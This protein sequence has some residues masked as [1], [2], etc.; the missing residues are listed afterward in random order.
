ML[1]RGPAQSVTLAGWPT[2]RRPASC[3]GTATAISV[4]PALGKRNDGLAG[5]N[6]L[7]RLGRDRRDDAGLVGLQ[8]RV[9]DRIGGLAQ[10]RFGASRARPRPHPTRC[11]RMS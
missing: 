10:L 11:V 8:R 7:A 5:A 6:D 3:S 9:A 4:S 1:S 2:D